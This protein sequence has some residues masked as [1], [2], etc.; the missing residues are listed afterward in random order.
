MLW[1]RELGD[2]SLVILTV[3]SGLM[4]QKHR[5]R[6][7]RSG[8]LR[9][10]LRSSNGLRNRRLHR[11]SSRRPIPYMRLRL[12]LRNHHRPLRYS[13]RS[14][15][16][17]LRLNHRLLLRLHKLRSLRLRVKH[18]R[19]RYLRLSLRYLRN[20][21]RRLLRLHLLLLR[22]LRYDRRRLLRLRHL[23]PLR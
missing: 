22:R 3:V 16:R 13:R 4:S 23:Q 14:L 15:H 9:S 19:L 17:N 6:H 10:H 2:V 5:T 21:L 1:I 12:W 20:R 8:R 7:W 18:L 11:R